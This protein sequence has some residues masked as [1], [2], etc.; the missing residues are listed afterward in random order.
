MRAT[1]IEILNER[2]RM[3]LVL[4][5][6]FERTFFGLGL[7]AAINLFLCGTYL[8]MKA[9]YD[10]LESTDTSVLVAGFMLALASFLITYLI[11]PRGRSALA[12]HDDSDPRPAYPKDPLFTVEA[13][14]VQARLEARRGLGDAKSMPGPM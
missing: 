4:R 13:E 7:F 8:L 11:W 14:A 6:R 3:P 12:R 10:P 2:N 1:R 9:L 5:A